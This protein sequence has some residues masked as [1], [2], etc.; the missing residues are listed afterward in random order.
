MVIREVFHIEVEDDAEGLDYWELTD[1][2]DPVDVEVLDDEIL[3]AEVI[4]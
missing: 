4:S 1:G 2:V 3:S